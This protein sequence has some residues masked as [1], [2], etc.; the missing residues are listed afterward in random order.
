MALNLAQRR[1]TNDEDDIPMA[2]MIDCVFLLLIFFMV[3]A[4]MKANPPFTITLPDSS[5]QHEFTRKKY[6]LFVNSDGRV[7]IDD[8]EMLTLEDMELFIAAHEHQI[9]TLIIKADKRAK[10]GVVIDVVERAKMRSSKTEGL[11]IAFAVSEE[12]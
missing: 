9:S 2:P 10:H 1:K 3:S 8:Q 5:T 4:V 7:S 12:D 6:N 11:E